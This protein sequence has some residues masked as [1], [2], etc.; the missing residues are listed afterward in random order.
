M[1]KDY[2]EETRQ[3]KQLAKAMNDFFEKSDESLKHKMMILLQI[4]PKYQ[5]DLGVE[6][7]RLMTE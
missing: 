7:I 2:A 3:M 1:V 5:Q 6:L 4:N